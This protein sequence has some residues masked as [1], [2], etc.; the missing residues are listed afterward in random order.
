MGWNGEETVNAK[1]GMSAS[2][3]I[4]LL[5]IGCI[6]LII[7]LLMMILMS[8]KTSSFS[9]Y[10]DDLAVDVAIENLLSTV[11]DEVYVNIEEFARIVGYEYHKGEYKSGTIAEDKCYVEGSNETTSFYLNDNKIYKL[12]VDK[13][14][15][16][17]EEYT[18]NNSTINLNDKMYA[19]IEIIAKAFNVSLELTD[20]Q[21][22]IYT[23]DNLVAIYDQNVISWGYESILEQSFENK[24]ALLYGFLIVRKQSVEEEQNVDGLYKIID[25]ENTK[26][27]VLDRYTSIEFSENTEEFIVTESS[28]KVGTINLDGTTRIETMYDSIS[29]LSKNYGLYIVKQNEKYGVISN[30]GKSIIYP[31][32]DGIGTTGGT[33]LILNE[34]IPVCKEKKWGAFNVNGELVFKLEY[35]ELGYNLNS[36]TINGVKEA[37][38]PLLVIER[39][40]GVVVGKANKYGLLNTKGK[41]LVPIAVD[42]IYGVLGAENENSKYFMLYN[43]EELNVIE[44]LIK[45]GEIK[46]DEEMQEQNGTENN[47]IINSSDTNTIYENNVVSE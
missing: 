42:G 3:K 41:E 29:L 19:P 32:Y 5:M 39:A 23:L 10:V 37:V 46:E 8:T 27:I 2:S 28:K 30:T 20:N 18:M 40:N 11:E 34:L 47:N 16:Q 14:D 13:R 44:R 7:M 9:V 45:A 26:E 35:D 38:Q 15:E 12:S 25:L 1:K 36:I 43:G 21:L 4:L 6:L 24:K 33:N 31:E 17:Y 22:R